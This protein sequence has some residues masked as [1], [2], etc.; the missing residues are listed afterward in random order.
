MLFIRRKLAGII[1]E[2]GPLSE[3]NGIFRFLKKVDHAKILNGF[4]QD[5]AYAV[6][7]YQV[8]D[9]DLVS[10]EPSNIFDR[11]LYNKAFTRTPRGST[12]LR[13]GLKR[14]R[15]GSMG[16]RIGSTGLRTRSTRL[17]AGTT[18]RRKTSTRQQPRLTGLRIGLTKRQRGLM[19]QQ[20]RLTKTPGIL[21]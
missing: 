4:V 1:A 7:D 13:I 10:L 9:A 17:P 6:T 5:S 16:L 8:W 11:H 21:S 12:G 14:L 3:Q 20:R 19:R 15:P 2:L 18:R